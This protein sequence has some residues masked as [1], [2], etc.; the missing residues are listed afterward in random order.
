V[1]EVTATLTSR[2]C[3]I[4]SAEKWASFFEGDRGWANVVSGFRARNVRGRA[5]KATAIERGWRIDHAGPCTVEVRYRVDF[6]FGRRQWEAGNEQVAYAGDDVVYTTGL[7]LFLLGDDGP[8]RVT[9]RVPTGWRVASPL[10]RDGE[11][12]SFSASNHSSLL[13]NTW[14]IGDAFV[15][16]FAAGSFTVTIALLGDMRA[17][18]D[19]LADAFGRIVPRY[20]ALAAPPDGSRYMF[21][22]FPGPEDGESFRDSFA[23]TT[24]HPPTVRNRI[25]W[26]N[27]LSHELLHYWMGHLLAPSTEAEDSLQWFIEGVTEYIANKTLFRQGLLSEVDYMNLLGRRL[28]VYELTRVNPNFMEVSPAAAGAQ[29]W[30]NRPLVYDGGASIGLCLDARIARGSGGAR[31]IEDVVRALLARHRDGTPFTLQEVVDE[32]SAAAGV[33]F[34]D[35]FSR[36]VSGLERI[37]IEECARDAGYDVLSHG[38]AVFLERV[39]SSPSQPQ[40]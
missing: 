40:R 36:Y 23:V 30:R 4:R 10:P 19:V 22:V 12:L 37:P 8:A 21:V 1:A 5:L 29:K 28:G 38:Y 32:S 31:G 35:F 33:D 11:A 6:A 24:V 26:G 7:P 25:V 15:R 14:V 2:D 34:S 17:G 3:V 27:H 16:D 13:E 39:S 9:M 20:T 18:A